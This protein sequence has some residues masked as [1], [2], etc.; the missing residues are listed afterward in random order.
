MKTSPV[1]P[2]DLR[3]SVL[4]V[5]PLARDAGFELADAPNRA[6]VRH[7][8]SGGVRT[9]MY[10][11]N[12]NLYHVEARQYQ[13]LLEALPAWAGDDTWVIP[14]MG[15]AYGQ[16]LEQADV[17]RAMGYPTA[18]ALPCLGPATPA[19]TA[20][21]VRKA[22]ERA[23]RPLIL[24]LKWDDYLPVPRVAEL[25]ADGVVCAIKYAIVRE[26]PADDAYL[27]ALLD[28]V[29]AEL[30]VSGIGERPAVV[31]WRD[32][33]LRAFTSG[34]ACV[35]PRQSTALLRA[36]Q[37]GRFDEAET[38]RAR[39]LPLEDLRD[40]IHPIRVLHD[41]VTESG[42]ADAG[43]LLPL[44]SGLDGGTRARVGEAARTLLAGERASARA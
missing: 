33:G 26:D 39:F 8:E 23:E 6:L 19:G 32:F 15:P 5:P 21:G 20:T 22:A 7:L 35:A 31:H 27:R 37:Q 16:L 25:V 14:S 40:G 30:V 1:T 29:D 43:P 41:A 13:A 4:A 9:L 17:V 28:A 11:G 44:L 38:I 3:R 2:A 24:Y 18:M 42:I 34:S 36:L 12:A 10:G